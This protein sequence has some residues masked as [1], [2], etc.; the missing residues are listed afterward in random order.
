MALAATLCPYCNNHAHMSVRW[1]QV[2][3]NATRVRIAATCDNC[4]KLVVAEGAGRELSGYGGIGATTDISVVRSSIP[5]VAGFEWLPLAGKSPNVEDVPPSVERAA[6][7]AYSNFSISNYMSSILMA[8]TVIEATAKAK[9]ITTGSLA[10][11]IDQLRDQQ[12]IRP[13]IALQAHQVRFFGND[14][15]HG[16][17]DDLPSGAD[18]EEILALMGEVLAEVFQGPARLERL[19]TRREGAA[20]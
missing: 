3:Q 4:D 5:R 19:R 20:E 17:I 6:K 15:A 12:Y 16:D 14:M 11:K 10:M 2:Y 7:E 13:A 8:R 1:G 18:A 9:D